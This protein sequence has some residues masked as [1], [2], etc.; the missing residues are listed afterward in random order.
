MA[1]DSRR[2]WSIAGGV[3]V[4]VIIV[5]AAVLALD[6]G[7]DKRESSGTLTHEQYAAK[8]NAI[9]A[10]DLDRVLVDADRRDLTAGAKDLA[11]AARRLEL[12]EP[13]PSDQAKVA[14]FTHNIELAGGSLRSLNITRFQSQ[15]TDAAKLA[16]ELGLD[17]CRNG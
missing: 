10:T 17:V 12:L 1:A 5:V 13:P 4:A 14:R 8:A 11:T 6:G 2:T 16:G 15:I 3:V 9:C 7:S